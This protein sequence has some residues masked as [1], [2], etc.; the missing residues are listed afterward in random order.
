MPEF[1]RSTPV[2]VT[3]HGHR[4]TVEITAEDRTTVVADVAPLDSSDASRSAAE[5][6]TVTLEGDTLAVR[7]PEVNGGRWRRSANL[8]ITVRVPTGSSLAVRTDSADVHARGSFATAEVR[9]ASG[10]LRIEDVT[11]DARTDTASGDVT[12][13][14]VG[15]ALWMGSASGDL[16]VGDVSGDVSLNTA[17]GDI[18]LQHA[19]ASV[20]VDTASGDVEIG[21]VHRGRT[22]IRSASGDV[23]IGV[24]AGTAVWLDLNTLSGSTRSDLAMAGEGTDPAPPTGAALELRVQTLSG[25]IHVRRAAVPAAA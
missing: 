8:A 24:A 25:D 11:G 14:R 7:T 12:I 5:A 23:R 20:G 16:R 6:A 15:G 22:G 17:S 9:T 3:V 1:D 2:T 18:A 19:G 13:G 4:G 21:V 10:D